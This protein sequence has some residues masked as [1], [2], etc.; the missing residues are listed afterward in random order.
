MKPKRHISSHLL[1]KKAF[2]TYL[3]EGAVL[4]SWSDSTLRC[5]EGVVPMLD[6]FD[7]TLTLDRMGRRTLEEI[8]FHLSDRHLANRSIAWYMTVLK[9]FLA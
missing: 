2:S 9:S 7:P 6:R 1:A 3:R 8:F 4:R 5:Y